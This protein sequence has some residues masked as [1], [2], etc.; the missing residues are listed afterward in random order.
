[1]QLGSSHPARTCLVHVTLN[2]TSANLRKGLHRLPEAA[3]ILDGLVVHPHAL[4]T[5]HASGAR[6]CTQ[7]EVRCHRRLQLIWFR[8]APYGMVVTPQM[9]ISRFISYRSLSAQHGAQKALRLGSGSSAR[10]AREPALTCPSPS[11]RPVRSARPY[12]GTRR[13]FVPRGLAAHFC[14]VVHTA[15][16]LTHRSTCAHVIA[17]HRDAALRSLA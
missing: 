15:Q 6:R 14:R 7:V 17:P 8:Y 1:M 12:R 16:T 13:K 9:P 2:S 10:P 11:A 5:R 4:G 3:A